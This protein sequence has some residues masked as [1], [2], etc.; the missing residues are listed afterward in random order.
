M[1]MGTPGV[2][3]DGILCTRTREGDEWNGWQRGNESGRM[4][5][6][7]RG[8]RKWNSTRETESRKRNGRDEG[9]GEQMRGD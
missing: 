6:T 2:E 8:R 7:A 4:E 5:E 9:R 3:S 1:E